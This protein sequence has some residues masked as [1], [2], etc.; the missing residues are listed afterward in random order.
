MKARKLIGYILHNGQVSGHDYVA[1]LTLKTSNRKTGNMA[2]IWF[3]LTEVNPVKVVKLGLDAETIC[4]SCPFASGNGCYVN[5]GQAP[6]SVW[7]AYRRGRYGELM[8][9]DYVGVLAGRKIRFGAYGN[10][11]LLPI[12]KVRAL[13]SVSEGWTGYYHD[14]RTNRY[15]AKYAEFFMA[16]TETTSSLELATHMGYRTFHVSPIKPKGSIECLADAKGL[17]CAQC[18]LCQGLTKDRQPS[19]WINPHGTREA[20]AVAAAL[21]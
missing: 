9:K 18:K 10:P 13:A 4:R 12:S 6:L 14:W 17:T 15:A 2:Q 8:P 19:V 3:L 21:A 16:S 11:T 7:R 5:V 1:I 20:K